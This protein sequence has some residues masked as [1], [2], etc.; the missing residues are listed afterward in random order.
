MSEVDSLAHIQEHFGDIQDPRHER[1]RHHKL[2]DILVIAI[3]AIICNADNWE[4]V[5]AFGEAK[6]T[7]FKGFLELP[8]GI[9]SHDTFTRVFARLNAKQFET[10]FL[11]WIAAAYKVTNG[12][13]V[14]IDGKLPRGSR[15][16]SI[17][18]GA[19]DMVSAWATQ[20]SL[21][22][23]Q[24]KVNQKTNGDSATSL[25]MKRV[26]YN[27]QEASRKMGW[28]RYLALKMLEAEVRYA[29]SLDQERNKSEQVE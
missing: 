5:E 6:E 24:V 11:S 18:K 13:V 27:K 9:P 10:C 25:V 2:I 28:M 26:K 8:N 29:T 1:T 7:W 14:A 21:V 20:N 23:G 12:Q 4:E 15:D 17:G 16:G 19:I 3:C 22:L